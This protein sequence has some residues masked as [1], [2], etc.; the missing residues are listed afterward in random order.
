VWLNNNSITRIENMEACFRL[1]ELYIENNKLASLAFIPQFKFLRSLLASNN[2]IRNLDK[3]LHFLERAS[4]LNSLDLFGNPLAEEPDYRLR[5]IYKCPQVEKLDRLGVTLP[6]RQRAEEVVPNMDKV[7]ASEPVKGKIKPFVSP[8]EKDCFRTA[9]NIVTKRKEDYV[10]SMV[11]KSFTTHFTSAT[12]L[13]NKTKLAMQVKWSD[14]IKNIEHEMN[15]PTPW[16]KKEMEADIK[17]LAGKEEL[18]KE[19]VVQLSSQLRDDGL[20]QVGRSLAKADVF[21]PLPTPRDSSTDWKTRTKD[22]VVKPKQLHPLETIMMDPAATM[23]VK[24]VIVY[25]LSLEWTRWSDSFLDDRIAQHYHSARIADLQGDADLVVT[26]RNAALRLEGVK[27]RKQRV[28]IAFVPEPGIIR[29]SRSDVLTQSLLQPYRG[30]DES[31]KTVVQVSH[32]PRSTK[33]CG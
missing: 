31:G 28:G 5:V 1:R 33:M 29:K 26:S 4:F 21:A 10:K 24:D 16:E 3:N 30:F 20:E 2:Q 15:T 27:T 22:S 9:K 18:T 8:M 25:F 13:E 14:P 17:Q 7:A 11:S 6:Q 32:A 23:P 19:D 12:A